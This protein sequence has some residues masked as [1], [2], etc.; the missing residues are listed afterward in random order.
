MKILEKI[1]SFF[2]R[3]KIRFDVKLPLKKDELS[4]VLS[5]DTDNLSATLCSDDIVNKNNKF[6]ISNNYDDDKTEI[7]DIVCAFNISKED[8]NTTITKMTR[9][10]TIYRNAKGRLVNVILGPVVVRNI[11]I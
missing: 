10:L 5:F 1:K 3:K 7:S 9:R 2:N 6:E 11:D 8:G 4:E